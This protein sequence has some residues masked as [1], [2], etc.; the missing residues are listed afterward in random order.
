MY[1]FQTPEGRAGWDQIQG[2]TESVHA[3]LEQMFWQNAKLD[4]LV[5]GVGGAAHSGS[6]GGDEKVRLDEGLAL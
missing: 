2:M 4:A 3:E 6:S 1:T 5:H